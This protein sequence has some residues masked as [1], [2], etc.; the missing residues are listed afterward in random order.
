MA[1]KRRTKKTLRGSSS[2]HAEASKN[3][4]QNL[5]DS[6]A[7]VKSATSCSGA[8]RA[9][10]AGAEDLG[11]AKTHH[12]NAAGEAKAHYREIADLDNELVVEGVKSVKL[13]CGRK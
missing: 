9:F 11:M 5:V 6:I 7:A 3:A 10:K 12:A 13:W 1:R 4:K 2:W 8:L